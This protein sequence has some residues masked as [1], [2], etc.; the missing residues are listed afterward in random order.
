MNPSSN[1]VPTQPV[2]I[3]GTSIASTPGIGPTVILTPTRVPGGNTQSQL[4]T[5]PDRILTITNV[6]KQ[7]G[8]DSSSIAI[9]LTITIKNTGAKTINNE[10]AYFQLTG[11]EG[12][13]FGLQSS[14]VPN[15]FGTIASQSSRSG[16]IVFM[17]P[18]GAVNGM[19][20]LYRPEITIET[21][22]VPLNL[23]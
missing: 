10:A 8:T 20:L 9:N 2:V 12:D 18:A 16:T 22:F 4:V 23:T 3:Q 14:A 13:V 19:R 17:V 7:V 11:A 15:F 1:T 5:L 21:I 6:S